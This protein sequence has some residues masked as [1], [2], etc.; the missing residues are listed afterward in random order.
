MMSLR[1]TTTL[2][3]NVILLVAVI[4]PRGNVTAGP[5]ELAGSAT[6][7]TE[8]VIALVSQK[9]TWW[10]P[11]EEFDELKLLFSEDREVEE[12]QSGS[13]AEI[14]KKEPLADEELGG[15]EEPGDSLEMKLDDPRQVDQESDGDEPVQKQSMPQEDRLKMRLLSLRKPAGSLTVGLAPPAAEESG[16]REPVNRAAAILSMQP[17]RRIDGAFDEIVRA[18]RVPVPFCHRPSYFQELNL[19]R[20]GQLDCERYGCMQNA[21]SSLWFLTNAALLPYRIASQSPC[22]CVGAYGDCPTCQRYDTSIEPLCDKMAGPKNKRGTL[23]QAASMAG[24]AFLIW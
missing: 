18:D 11:E 21:F 19:E 22:E 12:L 24:F 15:S 2:S 16:A 17:L 9:V 3:I 6:V 1:T 20:C 10:S 23:L 5:L 13:M 14:L 8:S 4:S 7:E